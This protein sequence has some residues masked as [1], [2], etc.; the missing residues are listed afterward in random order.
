[1]HTNMLA[2]K[3]VHTEVDLR[4]VSISS[5]NLGGLRQW[6]GLMTSQ[7]YNAGML[8]DVRTQEE[9]ESTLIVQHDVV[10]HH[11]RVQ[12]RLSRDALLIHG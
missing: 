7:L 11:L 1:M 10:H 2:A 9:I 6:L 12:H 8:V 4:V 5:D 3:L